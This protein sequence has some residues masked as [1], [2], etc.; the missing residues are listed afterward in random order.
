MYSNNNSQHSEHSDWMIPQ[1]FSAPRNAMIP[2]P[3]S[4]LNSDNAKISYLETS[5]LLETGNTYRGKE[6]IIKAMLATRE[7]WLTD[8]CCPS[9]S[10]CILIH[11][12]KELFV[13][14]KIDPS[15]CYIK[16]AEIYE[17]MREQTNGFSDINNQTN[18]LTI[19]SVTDDQVVTRLKKNNQ[20]LKA[21]GQDLVDITN[22]HVKFYCRENLLDIE[23]RKKLNELASASVSDYFM[24]H[25]IVEFKLKAKSKPQLKRTNYLFLGPP[26]SG[27]ST[28]IRA[29]KLDL[30]ELIMVGTDHY[31][32]FSSII[33]PRSPKSDDTT[34]ME[35]L[36]KYRN[37]MGVRTQDIAFLIK[38]SI[39]SK[40]LEEQKHN[41]PLPN[42]VADVVNLDHNIS[43]ILKH[44]LGHGVKLVSSVALYIGIN[45]GAL[46]RAYKRALQS[47]DPADKDR[48]CNT[49]AI[50]E[51]HTTLSKNLFRSIPD[52]DIT[53]I[54]NTDVANGAANEKIATINPMKNEIDVYSLIIFS[55]FL[56]KANL[57][58][59]ARHPVEMI[60]NPKIQN[61]SESSLLITDLDVR[62]KALLDLIKNRAI[63]KDSCCS[64]ILRDPQ[65]NEYAR[66]EKRSS[67]SNI[68]II[69]N[70]NNN[71]QLYKKFIQEN[72]MQAKILVALER[73]SEPSQNHKG[74]SNP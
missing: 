7:E 42:I 11:I 34:K 20:N 51:A 61:S 65:G 66:L 56:C 49:K 46:E 21:K 47:D 27:K 72:P 43:Q 67:D 40:I 35:D 69:R 37:T 31:R 9:V 5:S 62:A 29:K 39:I 13:N 74:I 48:Y 33:E 71:E 68:E 45:G 14:Y 18:N 57:N 60:L 26:A 4:K 30:S 38:T 63:E 10:T 3:L 58:I 64:L 6:E 12:A 1:S 17:K 25:A 55:S 23:R 22:K 70:T 19:D 16:A 52:F 24:N 32:A 53:N 50:N 8:V 44:G 54:Y 41:Q 2:G 28:L 73:L 59:Q 36:E 15:E